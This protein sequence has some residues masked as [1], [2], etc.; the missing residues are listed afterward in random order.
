MS[1]KL[2]TVLGKKVP[3]ISHLRRRAPWGQQKAYL[4]QLW[5]FGRLQ[6][7]RSLTKNPVGLYSSA[8]SI[9]IQSVWKNVG[10]ILKSPEIATLAT[11]RFAMNRRNTTSIDRVQY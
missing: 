3:I 7:A 9:F 11:H 6:Q 1:Q 2:F 10:K 4:A 5:P 8:G